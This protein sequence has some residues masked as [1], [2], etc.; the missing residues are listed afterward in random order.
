MKRCDT[1]RF[2]S[3]RLAFCEGGGPVKAMCLCT[4]GPK[5]NEYTAGDNFCGG[6]KS[7]HY[8]AIDSPA[9]EGDEVWRLYKQ[10]DND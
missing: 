6:W 5:D 9:E 1:C 3:E 8:G 7:G 10:E 2:W 4:G